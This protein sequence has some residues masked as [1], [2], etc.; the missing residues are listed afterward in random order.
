MKRQSNIRRLCHQALAATL[1]TGSLI[2]TGLLG[3]KVVYGDMSADVKKIEQVLQSD[4]G[5]LKTVLG[6]ISDPNTLFALFAIISA[7]VNI[8]PESFSFI[9]NGPITPLLS[10]FNNPNK[11]DNRKAVVNEIK[12]RVSALEQAQKLETKAKIEKQIA[13]SELE[14]TRNAFKVTIENLHKL[15]GLLDT[16]KQKTRKVEEDY[17]Q[18]KTDKEKAEADKRNAE[19]KA[20]TAEE[21]A[22]QATADKEKAETEAKK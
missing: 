9:L 7:D 1:I 10:Y 19:T 22:K 18:A 11:N 2:G 16:E 20:R 17:Q 8:D 3:N 13:E 4:S 21:E 14:K 15:E 12:K 5:K 6:Q